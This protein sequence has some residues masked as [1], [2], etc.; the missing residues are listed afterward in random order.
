MENL[1]LQRQ[2]S[3]PT[4]PASDHVELFARHARHEAAATLPVSS[5]KVSEGHSAHGALPDSFLYFP[6]AQPVQPLAE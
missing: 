5:P 3:A 6:A 1:P 2:D 4:C